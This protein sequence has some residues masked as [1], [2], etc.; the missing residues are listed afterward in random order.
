[1]NNHLPIKVTWAQAVRDIINTAI[2][3]GQLPIL[4]MMMAV[5]LILYRLPPS[6]ISTLVFLVL[7]YLKTGYFIGY[8]LF[9]VTVFLWIRDAK[10]NRRN[11]AKLETEFKRYL[12]RK[13]NGAKER[14]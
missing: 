9:I 1:M 12:L 3:R 14:K 5:L 13:K 6:D 2:N 7:N 4:I 10:R 11:Y 8:L